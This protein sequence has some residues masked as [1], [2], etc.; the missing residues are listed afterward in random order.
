VDQEVSRASGAGGLMEEGGLRGLSES[1][2]TYVDLL[3]TEAKSV[4][5]RFCIEVMPNNVHMD[6]PDVGLRIDSGARTVCRIFWIRDGVLQQDDPYPWKGPKQFE[7][8]EAFL[9]HSLLPKPPRYAYFKLSSKKDVAAWKKT[10][11]R[12][13][14]LD[15]CI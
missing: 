1:E 9:E 8:M 10:L 15:K 5:S 13:V 11:P 12:L 2:K 14:M 7:S 4:D 6:D 3:R